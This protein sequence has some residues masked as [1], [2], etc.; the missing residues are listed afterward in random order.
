LWSTQ[1]SRTTD[2]VGARL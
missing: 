2:R 1:T